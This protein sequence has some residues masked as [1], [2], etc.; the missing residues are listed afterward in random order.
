MQKKSSIVISIKKYMYYQGFMAL[1]LVVTYI[2]LSLTFVSKQDFSFKL[3]RFFDLDSEMNL[4][5]FFSSTLILINAFLFYV[6]WLLKRSDG[7]PRIV[8]I[9]FAVMFLFLSMDEYCSIHEKV[10]MVFRYVL[11]LT[12]KGYWY[13]TWIVPYGFIVGLISFYFYKSWRRLP[14]FIKV[15]F[16]CSALTYLV[17]AIGFEVIGEKIA[18]QI[19][20]TDISYKIVMIMEESLEMAGQLMLEFTLLTMIRQLYSDSVLRLTD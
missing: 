5:T 11:H 3:F 17:G 13:L 15:W 19:G 20:N 14:S 8:W 1:F 18:Q 9:F 10:G 2:V 16:S 7:E 12:A 4:P 6:L